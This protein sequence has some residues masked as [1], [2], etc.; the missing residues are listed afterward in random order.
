MLVQKPWHTQEPPNQI[1]SQ[2]L[3]YLWTLAASATAA[4][5]EL[6]AEEGREDVELLRIRQRA[7]RRGLAGARARRA[8]ELH[9]AVAGAL[10]ERPARLS[11]ASMLVLRAVAVAVGSAPTLTD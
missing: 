3:H 7:E 9:R 8:L 11:R 10:A 1:R 4:E 6:A 5:V 2:F